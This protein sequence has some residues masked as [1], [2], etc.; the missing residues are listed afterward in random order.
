MTATLA[1]SRFIDSQRALIL[2]VLQAARWVIGG[3]SGAAAHLGLKRTTLVAKMKKLGISRPAR[4]KD[5][6]KLSESRGS[7][8][9]IGS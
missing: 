7:E 9:A 8:V 6:N 2:E 1:T 5:M 3:P 4:Q